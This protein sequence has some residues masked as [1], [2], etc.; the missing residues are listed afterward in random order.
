MT[1]YAF[2]TERGE[3]IL[4]EISEIR[5]KCY[6]MN[7]ETLVECFRVYSIKEY[8]GREKYSAC[9]EA[10]VDSARTFDALKDEITRRLGRGK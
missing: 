3:D 5:S 10:Y 6:K 2:G 9:D 4:R 1:T 7:N 8:M